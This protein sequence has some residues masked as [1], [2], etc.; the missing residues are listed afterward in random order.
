M[1]VVDTN[2]EILGV[3]RTPDGPIFGTDVSLQ[4]ARTAM[5]FSSAT[6][7]DEMD[8]IPAINSAAALQSIGVLLPDGLIPD[9]LTKSNG[10]SD[11]PSEFWLFLRASGP[12]FCRARRP[13]RTERLL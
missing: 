3:A 1:S 9:S 13:N 6:A 7:G 5:F 4:K 2:G 12:R 8:Q 11:H 10:R